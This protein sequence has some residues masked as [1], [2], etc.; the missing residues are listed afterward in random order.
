MKKKVGIITTGQSP[1]NEYRSFHR[2]ALAA[3]GLEVDVFERACLDG[4]TREEIRAH[5][6]NHTGGIA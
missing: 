6:I 1:R 2:N 3:L 4:L 5:E